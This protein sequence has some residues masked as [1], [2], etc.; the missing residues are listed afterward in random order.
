MHKALLAL[1]AEM[2]QEAAEERGAPSVLPSQFESSGRWGVQI[3]A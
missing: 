1:R 3:C 2:A